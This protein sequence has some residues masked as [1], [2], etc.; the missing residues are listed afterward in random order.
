MDRESQLYK[1]A[2]AFL[3][4]VG[5]ITIKSLIAYCGGAKELFNASHAKLKKAPG[6]GDKRAKDILDSDALK[7]AEQELKFIDKNGIQVLYYLDDDFPKRLLGCYDYPVVMFYKG[8]ANLNNQKVLSIVGT[9]NATEYGK[10]V[11][12]QLVEAL[13]P[14]NVLIVSGLAYGIDI[15][16]H[17]AAIHSGL[18]TVG[19][20][21][22]GLD[23]L[24]PA[25]HKQTAQKM[26]LNGGLLSDFPSGTLP[27]KFNFPRRNRIVAGIADA[28]LVVE[29]KIKGG[30][31]ITAE[32]ANSYN[33]DIL[34]V[35]G[36]INSA[37]SE[38]CNYLI[39]TNRASLVDNGE[40]IID[41]LGWREESGI[42]GPLQKQLF[43]DLTDD[44]QLIVDLLRQ[45]P[46]AIDDLTLQLTMP[47]SLIA[48]NLLNLELKGVVKT[49]PGKVYA[50]MA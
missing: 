10:A 46:L 36:N 24:Y 35:P 50:L 19:V 33:R 31:M 7:Q 30:S 15:A 29:T 25:L 6:I 16:A 37:V 17:K 48:A 26:E 38:G 20:L 9:R 18:P 1:V 32:L 23:R 13:K 8:N 3:P 42:K 5:D 40:E 11:T 27:D 47:S 49:L 22:H 44:E 34:A 43:L 28:V 4:A 2:L 41:L 14:Y 12:Q 39:K 45:K 21:G